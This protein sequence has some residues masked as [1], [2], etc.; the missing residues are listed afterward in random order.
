MAPP[1]HR[2]ATLTQGPIA[3]TLLLFALPILASNVLQS[4]NASVN[5]IWVGH[6]L[7]ESAFAA[8]SNA[9]LILFFL[10]GVVF[11]ISMATT[12]LVGQT[13]GAGDL[14]EAKRVVGTGTVFFVVLSLLVALGG[15]IG[16]PG[17][18]RAMGT[19]IDAQPYAIAYLRIIFIA[20]PAMYFFNFLMMTLRGAGDSRTP[21]V[22]MLVSVVLDVALNPLFIFGWG[23]VPRMG[24]AGSAVATLIAQ[25]LALFGLIAHLYRHKHF[26]RIQRHEWGLLRPDPAVLRSLVLKGLPMGMQMIV[27][28]SAAIVMISLV[29]RHGSQTTAAY[30]AAAQLWTYIQM[31]A[32]AIG[33]AVS[34]MVAQNVGARLWD[35]VTRIGRV[36]VGFNFLMT[37]TLV[38]LI[39]LF[40]R[41]ALGLFL[42]GDGDAIAIAQHLNAI[43]VWS[44]L[45]FGVTFVIFGVVR[46]TGAVMAP[47]VILTVSM[48]GVRYPFAALL[49]PRFGADAIWWSFPLSSLLAV[50]MAMTYYRY[51]GWRKARMLAE[52]APEAAQAPTTGVGTPAMTAKVED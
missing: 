33:A 35:R 34:S 36:G 31:P 30:G 3:S 16:T 26:L 9:N 29:N 7:G 14:A 49:E 51:G 11:G 27:I 20:L 28:S 8:T 40:N 24:I 47:L 19:P 42:P 10:L 46:A 12:I 41:Y 5:A 50:T 17:L 1:A 39:Y 15:F 44:F 13:T 48:W 23:P 45:F 4:L 2:T 6:F 25:T 43:V 38:V 21:F 22:F 18:L 32:L 52:P 37:G